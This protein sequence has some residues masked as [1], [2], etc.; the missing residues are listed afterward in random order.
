MASLPVEPP[1]QDT[2]PD[3]SVPPFIVQRNKYGPG[4]HGVYLPDGQ[5]VGNWLNEEHHD[6]AGVQVVELLTKMG[7]EGELAAQFGLRREMR[8]EEEQ[9]LRQHPGVQRAMKDETERKAAKEIVQK[10]FLDAHKKKAK[11]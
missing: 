5:A 11:E 2:P 3:S 8:I 4:A 9:K 6:L 7:L 10:A 1:D